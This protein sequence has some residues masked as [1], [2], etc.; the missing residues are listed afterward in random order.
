MYEYAKMKESH[1]FYRRTIALAPQKEKVRES[2]GFVIVYWI[3]TPRTVNYIYWN[4]VFGVYPFF[5]VY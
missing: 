5:A 1:W 3:I 2:I 4:C